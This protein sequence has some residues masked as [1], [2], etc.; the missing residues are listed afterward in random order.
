MLEVSCNDLVSILVVVDWSARPRRDDLKKDK[1]GDSGFN[2]CCS[3]LVGETLRASRR[4]CTMLLFPWVSILV[5]VDWSAR[6]QR[7]LRC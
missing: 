5:V 2:P 6:P 1:D 4:L 7:S 3:G